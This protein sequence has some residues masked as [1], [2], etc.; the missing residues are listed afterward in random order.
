MKIL[1]LF[2]LRISTSPTHIKGQ[3]FA[4]QVVARSARDNWNETMPEDNYVVVCPGPD[5]K[6]FKEPK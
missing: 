5:H 6:K 3:Y 1:R 2:A 4:T